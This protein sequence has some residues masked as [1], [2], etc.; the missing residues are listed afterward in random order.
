MEQKQKKPL[1]PFAFAALSVVSGLKLLGYLAAWLM[2][3]G[4]SFPVGKAATIGIIGGADGPT[5][6]FVTAAAAPAW[7]ILL[8]LALFFGGIFGFRHFLNCK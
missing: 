6:I 3:K 2:T 7:E 5:A 1:W 4:L 8:W